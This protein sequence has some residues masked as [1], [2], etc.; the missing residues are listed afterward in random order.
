ML[1][2][3]AP[4]LATLAS[5]GLNILVSAITAKGKQVVEETLGVEIPDDASKLT[6]EK[7]AELRQAEMIHETKLLELSL[8]AKELDYERES[9]GATEVTARWV[10]DMASDNKLSKNIRPIVLLYLLT[11][12]TVFSLLSAA[13]VNINQA[14]VELLGQMLM[15][16][17]SAYFVGRTVEKVID[18]N[19]SAAVTKEAIKHGEK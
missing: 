4:I 13:E 11:A 15:L 6:P 3:L 5:N 17:F 18:I 12:Y 9:K 16:A 19:Q 10:A 1:P 14:Y 2:I 7:I 8:K